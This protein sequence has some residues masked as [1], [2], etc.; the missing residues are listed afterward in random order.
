MTTFGKGILRWVW[1]IPEKSIK[2]TLS[3]PPRITKNQKVNGQMAQAP[4]FV[5]FLTI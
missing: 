4:L 3:P 1:C 5:I 2:E